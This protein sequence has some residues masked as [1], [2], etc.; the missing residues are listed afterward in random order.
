MPCN[1]GYKSYAKIEIPEPQ[2]QVFKQKANAPEIDE[3]LLEKLGE[4]DE[5]FLEWVKELDTKSLLKKALKRALAKIDAKGIDFKIN[6]QGMLE[7]TSKFINAQQRKILTETASN[8]SER[9][10][11]E[12]LGIVA[13]LL[14]YDT[15]MSI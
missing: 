1:I 2:P 13:E 8:I 4:E 9:W 11:F 15:T 12:V 3:E 5:Q 14:D 6:A 10:Q 7:A